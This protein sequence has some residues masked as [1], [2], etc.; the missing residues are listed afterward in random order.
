M[1]K[2]TKQYPMRRDQWIIQMYDFGRKGIKD[3]G[4]LH[5]KVIPASKYIIY[6]RKGRKGDGPILKK[7]D[8]NLDVYGFD[9]PRKDIEKITLKNGKIIRIGSDHIKRDGDYF[10]NYIVP[11]INRSFSNQE[12]KNA[13]IYIEYPS[14]RLKSEY[15]GVA[16]SYISDI[17]KQKFSTIHVSNKKDGPT[18][19]HEML[20]AVRFKDRRN[21]KSKNL[22]EAETTLGTFARLSDY[23][24]K[25][26]PCDDG[27]YHLVKGDKCKSRTEDIKLIK[28]KCN[29]RNKNEL[30]TC[31]RKNIKNTHI[32][33]IKIPK[34]YIP[35]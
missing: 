34:K 17:D 25:K 30:T 19:I 29:I 7:L 23:E 32:G 24:V 21:T 1:K 18:I 31:I 6:Y 16:I 20:H 10:K 35:K 26:I 9:L 14:K 12:L 5:K 4:H 3:F 13:E 28:Q 11:L 22:D 8:P 2:V 33:K 27:Y 15:D